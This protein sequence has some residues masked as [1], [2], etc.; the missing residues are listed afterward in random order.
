M[1]EDSMGLF[2]IQ[3][4]GTKQSFQ[5]QTDNNNTAEQQW[6]SFFMAAA[7]KASAQGMCT[8]FFLERCQQ[9]DFT[10]G[11]SV[12]GEGSGFACQLIRSWTLRKQFI[13]YTVISLSEK[14]WEMCVF[15][16]PFYIEP[17]GDNL[18]AQKLA[19]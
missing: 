5:K 19:H 13:K 4:K 2:Q 17:W 12:V 16:Y 18:N 3:T 9:P 11:V 14:D 7:T 6:E 1:N 15:A 10:V 8:S